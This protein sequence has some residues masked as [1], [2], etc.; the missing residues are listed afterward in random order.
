MDNTW[1]IDSPEGKASSKPVSTADLGYSRKCLMPST[2]KLSPST[3]L[4]TEAGLKLS[5]VQDC[6]KVRNCGHWA[7]TRGMNVTHLAPRDDLTSAN[8]S[9]LSQ[10]SDDHLT[11]CDAFLHSSMLVTDV[12][13]WHETLQ[14]HEYRTIAMRKVPVPKRL[15]EHGKG[16]S[17][18]NDGN[19]K[20]HKDNSYPGYAGLGPLLPST[21]NQ[22]KNHGPYSNIR[23]T[24]V[25]YQAPQDQLTSANRSSYPQ[26]SGCSTLCE[27]LLQP[28]ILVTGVAT[29][30][31][32]F[33]F[34]ENSTSSMR[35]IPAPERHLEQSDDISEYNDVILKKRLKYL[36]TEHEGQCRDN[37]HKSA[38]FLL[39]IVHKSAVYLLLNNL[40]PQRL[41]TF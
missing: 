18:Y 25:T 10:I 22:V 8:K 6:D 5:V 12:A 37:I 23:Q 27:A 35:L 21:V 34:D 36:C 39:L 14:C 33:H 26:K 2:V 29:S 24:R 32:K 1:K 7:G 15:L 4:P 40:S 20:K 3:V 30:H 17:E 31:E 13:N 19:L 41:I 38:E 11:L 28:S 16:L 9:Y